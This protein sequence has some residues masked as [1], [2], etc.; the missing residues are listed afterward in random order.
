MIPDDSSAEET[1]GNP[2][3]ESEW[4]CSLI[5]KGILLPAEYTN[6]RINM[7]GLKFL[8]V[9]GDLDPYL[10]V[11]KK[12]LVDTFGILKDKPIEEYYYGEN[13]DLYAGMELVSNEVNRLIELYGLAVKEKFLETA[14]K[15]SEAGNALSFE[16]VGRAVNTT[17]LDTQRMHMMDQT[18][19][20]LRYMKGIVEAILRAYGVGVLKVPKKSKLDV[21]INT[22]YKLFLQYLST[23]LGDVS[24]N[25]KL[26]FTFGCALDSIFSLMPKDDNLDP[27]IND[28]CTN[29]LDVITDPKSYYSKCKTDS[30][31]SP[32]IGHLFA[33]SYPEFYD[34]FRDMFMDDLGSMDY[35]EV[36]DFRKSFG[37]EPD[38]SQ[39]SALCS[40]YITLG[41]K[42]A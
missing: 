40:Q 21:G 14:E 26:A 38:D 17:A 25:G 33:H 27:Y 39:L 30:I 7:A 10:E 22:Q 6:L 15:I 34:K 41:F 29:F 36:L 1:V 31:V 24:S 23:N 12:E 16:D 32:S 9:S 37:L 42:H 4:L 35:Q 28:V 2:E 3:L 20:K 19:L 5:L 8:D 18:Q 13:P 11:L